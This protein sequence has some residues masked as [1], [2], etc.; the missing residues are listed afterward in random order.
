M[1]Q[2]G[3]PVG[4]FRPWK[5]YKL[6]GTCH[7]EP[8]LQPLGSIQHYL[9][10]TCALVH[11]TGKSRIL[12]VGTSCVGRDISLVGLGKSCNKCTASLKVGNQGIKLNV[13]L[14][15]TRAERLIQVSAASS[16]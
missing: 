11:S 1:R 8:L 2:F 16:T 15:F 7:Q 9:S 12:T 13:R 4:K 3:V 10:I 6:H 14:S 5:G